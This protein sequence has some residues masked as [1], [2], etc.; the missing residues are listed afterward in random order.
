MFVL[1]IKTVNCLTRLLCNFS[2]VQGVQGDAE[3]ALSIESAEGASAN[4]EPLAKSKLGVK[5]KKVVTSRRHTLKRARIESSEESEGAQ[6]EANKAIDDLTE[7]AYEYSRLH[8]GIVGNA[9][10][11]LD[12]TT[13]N[14]LEMSVVCGAARNEVIC[15]PK[16]ATRTDEA[17]ENQK[18]GVENNQLSIVPSGQVEDLGGY[19]SIDPPEMHGKFKVVMSGLRKT[20]LMNA[21]TAV[22]T[23]NDM[24]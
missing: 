22:S 3:N 13:G 2:D 1:R 20:D 8:S 14:N 7:A 5:R 6:E 12:N 21:F 17:A 24:V 10:G 18:D 15:S 9:T 19:L 11:L 23:S 4:V 16:I